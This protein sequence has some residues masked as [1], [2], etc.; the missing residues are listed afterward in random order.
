ML[1]GNDDGIACFFLS[2][3]DAHR[4]FSVKYKDFFRD[5]SF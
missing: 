2:V 4:Y 5:F 3:D 1:R